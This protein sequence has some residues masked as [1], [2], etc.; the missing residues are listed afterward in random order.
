MAEVQ[1]TQ[2]DSE[3]QSSPMEDSTQIP[4]FT[5]QDIK[6][7]K[8]QLLTLNLG[9]LCLDT[10]G[11]VNEKRQRLMDLFY[12][13]NDSGVTEFHHAASVEDLQPNMNINP[14][15][16]SGVTEFHHAASV[17]VLQADMNINPSSGSG[18]TDF[19][20]AASV[21]DLQPDMNINSSSGSG[22]TPLHHASIIE[23]ITKEVKALKVGPLRD[24][25]KS[26][27]LDATGLKPVLRQRL[28]DHLLADSSE[29]IENETANL[30][31]FQ[32]QGSVIKQIPKASRIQAGKSF[33]EILRRVIL[34]NDLE[35]W[36]EL[37][38][39][40]RDFF[41]TP[42]RGGQKTEVTGHLDK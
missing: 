41:G 20:H 27:D 15:S 19:H 33:A 13:K 39:F 34:K 8:D 16:G 7:M 30:L 4:K 37:F 1:D 23:G 31:D 11:S 22:F 35:S 3:S 18:V 32:R 9:K 26:L 25:L 5:R 29:E 21:E 42:N 10:T 36:G 40:A 38:R 28:L 6:K 17:E 12:P 2:N 24:K 14:S